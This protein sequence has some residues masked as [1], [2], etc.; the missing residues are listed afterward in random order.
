MEYQNRKLSGEYRGIIVSS[1]VKKKMGKRVADEKELL[2]LT[3]T[4][5][6]SLMIPDNFKTFQS[7]GEL[8]DPEWFRNCYGISVADGRQYRLNFN[9]NETVRVPCSLMSRYDTRIECASKELSAEQEAALEKYTTFK[10]ALDADIKDLKTDQTGYITK[11][12]V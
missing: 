3:G 5:L 8:Y 1:I 6:I 12:V 11:Y 7:V 9:T 4:E 2:I 10:D